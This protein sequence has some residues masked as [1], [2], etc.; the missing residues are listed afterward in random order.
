MTKCAFVTGASSGI[1]KEVAIQFAS[2][3]YD[4]A[5]HYFHGQSEA[6]ELVHMIRERYSVRCISVQADVS[7]ENDV[8]KMVSHV[9]DEFGKID[10]LVNSA[11]IAIDTLFEDKSVDDF[12]RIL[13][14]NLIGTFLV[15]KYV[16]AAMM[17]N[18]SG[19]IINIGSTNG[20]DS[21]YPY[22]M[23]Y[24]A[25]KAGIHNLTKNLAVQFA[26]YIR[27]NAV[28]PGWVNTP[29][30]L[31]LD[32]DFIKEEKKKILLNRFASPL[33]IAHVILFLASDKASYVNGS[34][35]VVD[36][37]RR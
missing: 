24:D 2:N 35:I 23:D 1:G 30:N 16:S 6:N 4:V 3:G 13:D 27:V 29:M 12:K 18:K 8:K 28:A 5:V 25:S 20:I 15:C 7:D 22:S 10:V 37:G 32:E 17:Q 33:E 36:G 34:I 21:Y 11:G 31:E 9:L 19:C 26:P 14:V